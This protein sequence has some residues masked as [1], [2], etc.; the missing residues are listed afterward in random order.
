MI[1]LSL[2]V[3][4]SLGGV[5]SLAKTT[6]Q[7]LSFK[8]PTKWQKTQPDENSLQ[9]DEPESGASLAVSV[10]GVDPQRPAAACVKQLVEAVGAEGFSPVTLGAS[11]A[12]KKIS[13]DYVGEGEAAK[14]DAN[15]V[16]TTTV[17]GCNG[18]KKWVLTWTA[19]TSEGARFG[20]ILKRVL[21]SISYGK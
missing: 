8:A 2:V 20:P 4:V 10:Y 9:W 7:G 14:T 6:L 15:K 13:S 3:A 1:A 17:L 21:D 11:P 5:D 19:K 18:K 16:T 12:S